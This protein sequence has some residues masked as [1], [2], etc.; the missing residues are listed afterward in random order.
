MSLALINQALLIL[1]PRFDL[2]GTNSICSA[3][4]WGFA[5]TV[6]SI[7]FRQNRRKPSALTSGP[8]FAAVPSLRCR[9]GATRRRAI[10]GPTALARH[11]CRAHPTT[12]PPLSLPTRVWRCLPDRGTAK[13]KSKARAIFQG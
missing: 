1:A 12:T 9:G 5:L 11:P 2:S 6:E 8:C 3:A 7:L 4:Y 13:R 10:P